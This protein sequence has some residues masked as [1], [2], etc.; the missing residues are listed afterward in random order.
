M[1][2]SRTETRIVRRLGTLAPRRLHFRIDGWTERERNTHTP[3]QTERER[4]R[5]HIT[6]LGNQICMFE[7]VSMR[8]SWLGGVQIR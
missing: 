8:L 6:L 7:K 5:G 1:K 2:N 3:A 4:E